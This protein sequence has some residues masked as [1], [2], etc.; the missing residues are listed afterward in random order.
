M[1]SGLGFIETVDAA[2]SPQR[3][4]SMKYALAACRKAAQVSWSSPFRGSRHELS[5]ENGSNMF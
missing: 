3:A 1:G 4:A 2:R 5:W